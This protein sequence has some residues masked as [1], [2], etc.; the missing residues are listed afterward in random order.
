MRADPPPHPTQA[1]LFYKLKAASGDR[2]ENEVRFFERVGEASSSSPPDPIAGHTPRY[3]G[4]VE[5]EGQQYLKMGSV[6]EGF[7][8]PHLLEAGRKPH[9]GRR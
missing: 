8:R 9:S 3:F 5:R 6:T 2:F 1:G 4:V 7:E